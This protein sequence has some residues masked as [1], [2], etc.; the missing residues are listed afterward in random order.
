MLKKKLL[1]LLGV[2]VLL[3]LA[4][5]GLIFVVHDGGG[6]GTQKHKVFVTSFYPV[7]IL[8]ENLTEGT[9]TVVTNLAD[10]QTGCLHD[11]QITT[12]D[13]RLL[14]TADALILNGAGMELFLEDIVEQ[15]PELPVLELSE[16]ISLLSGPVHDHDHAHAEDEEHEHAE[17][18]EHD[19]EHE[20]A[21]EHEHSG[22]NGHVWMDIT[23]YR[24]QAK[25]LYR[26]L[27]LLDPEQAEGYRRAYE[28]YEEKLAALE[29]ETDELS[30]KTK[31]LP[32]VL[33]HEAYPYLADRLGME[34]LV[35][36]ALDEDAVPS[37]GEIAEM[38]KELR[39]HGGGLI[40]IEEQYAAHADKILAETEARVVFIDPLTTGDGNPDS[41]LTQMRANLEAIREAIG[42]EEP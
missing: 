29:Q 21:G 33:F 10:Q 41:Y 7:Y 27:V 18:H 42:G 8:A 19:E 26:G 15:E 14:S 23:R 6:E 36:V 3:S 20:H 37:A 25:T 16:G 1:F 40:L 32:V 38:I 9:R 24:Q 34:V 5:A 22:E 4:G 2:M 39:Q 17:E 31:G 12:K 11:Y 35:S 30:Q 13:R 28:V